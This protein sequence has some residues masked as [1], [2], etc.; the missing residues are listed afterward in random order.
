MNSH[1]TGS[2]ENSFFDS[3]VFDRHR[4]NKLPELQP[5]GRNNSKTYYVLGVDVGRFKCTTEICV[6]KVTPAPTGVPIKHLVNL[7]SIE[8]EHFGMQALFIKKIF[9]KYHCKAAVIDANGV[10]AGLVDLL[11]SDQIDPETNEMWY[12]LGVIYKD[13]EERKAYKKYENENTIDKAIYLMKANA[14]LNSEM[15]SYCQTQMQHGKLKFLVHENIAKADRQD[16]ASWKKKKPEAR[17]LDL[18]PYVMTTALEEQMLN[19]VVQNDNLNN[20]NIILK[21]ANNKTKHDRFSAFIYGLYYCKMIEDKG[22]K[23]KTRDFS[24]FMLF[25]KHH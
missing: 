1:W 7:Y 2:I 6:F 10:G 17:N 19:M 16:Q 18:M 11:V 20:G 24:Q 5:N 15:Y 4:V 12:N 9:S 23:R 14:N 25:S 21:P 13:D 8:A 3:E 22:E